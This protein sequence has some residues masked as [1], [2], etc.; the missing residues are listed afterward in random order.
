MSQKSFEE[1]EKRQTS[2]PRITAYGFAIGSSQ[3]GTIGS[4]YNRSEPH[5]LLRARARLESQSIPCVRAGNHLF[6]KHQGIISPVAPA[7]EPVDCGPLL[8]RRLVR[9]L[10]GTMV[11]WTNGVNPNKRPAEWYSVICRMFAAPEELSM[12]TR[13]K[14]KRGLKACEAR[15]NS[16]GELA[17]AG[18]PV[19]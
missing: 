4:S 17:A 10:G 2:M 9:E 15:I 6:I 13:C 11:R 5:N 8:S 19:L 3:D 1:W 7:S 12:R 14:I 16:A 18:Y